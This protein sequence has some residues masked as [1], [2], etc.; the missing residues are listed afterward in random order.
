[1]EGHALRNRI[2]GVQISLG[3]CDM[4]I[5]M[6][7]EDNNGQRGNEARELFGSLGVKL[8]L[9]I[10]YN[11]EANGKIERVLPVRCMGGLRV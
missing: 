1:M 4:S 3:I 8:S 6:C 7:M 5:W 11:L 10:A 2:V 9:T